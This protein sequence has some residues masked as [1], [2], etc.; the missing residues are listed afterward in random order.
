M[1]LPLLIQLN[2]IGLSRLN[3]NDVVM[4]NARQSSCLNTSDFT[5]ALRIVSTVLEAELSPRKGK[6]TVTYDILH[7]K[8]N[9]EMPY[10]NFSMFLQQAESALVQLDTRYKIE[11]SEVRCA[12]FFWASSVIKVRDFSPL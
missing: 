3:N 1:T 4:D 10:S 6:R 12:I 7:E 11:S 9:V 8:Y 2:N 5:K